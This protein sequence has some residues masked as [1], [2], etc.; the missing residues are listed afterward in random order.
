[1]NVIEYLQK[2][3]CI[4]ALTSEE[5]AKSCEKPMKVY[6]GFDPTAD[7]LHLGNLFGIILLSHFQRFGHTPVIV[8][9]GTTGR[10]GDPSGKSIERPLLDVETILNN[11]HSIRL[12]FEQILDF[13]GDLPRPIIVNNDEWYQ[14]FGVIDFM[15]EVGKHFRVGAMLS[16]ESVKARLHSEEGIS[17]TEFSYQLIQAYDFY[18]LNAQY[19]V[20]MQMGGSDQWGNITAGIDLTR[21]LTGRSVYG[22]TWPL[23]TRSDGKKF[24][25]SEEGAIWLSAKKCSPY[26]FYQYLMRIPDDDVISMMKKLTYMEL[27]EIEEIEQQMQSS[28]YAPNSAQKRLAEEITRIVHGK[29]GLEKALKV[30]EGAA[31]GKEA[32]LDA[33]VLREIAQDMPN[34]SLSKEDVVGKSYAELAALS[35]LLTSK[36]EGGRMLK[37]GGAY[38]NNDKITDPAKMVENGDLIDGEYLL[39]GAGKKKK[40]LIS[41]KK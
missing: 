25:K 14:N 26:Q 37:N 1:M 40:V 3:G 24:G 29:E 28:S 22:L 36:G 7:S 12:H 6:V 33:D 39:L 11:V 34:I 8:L 21:R 30:T 13:E 15:R 32:K 23:L 27:E 31:P 38:L 2:R 16:K 18:Y 5:I 4:D 35:G 19:D 41:M 20:S 9:G 17:Y 10:I